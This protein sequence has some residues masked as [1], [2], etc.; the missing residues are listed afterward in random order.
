[1]TSIFHYTDVNGLLGILSS[2]ALFATHHRYLNDAT[3]AGSIRD[4]IL[5]I[6]HAEIAAIT[7]KLIEK[8]WLKK[9]YYE[10]LGSHADFLQA[11][12]MYRAFI[13]GL[14][15]TTPFFVTS[16][17][18]HPQG[19]EEYSHGLLS[20]WR[21]YAQSGGFAIEFDEAQFGALMKSENEK[22]SYA[23]LQS[24]DVHY[25]QHE[26][27]FDSQIYSGVARE[28]IY[29]MFDSQNIDVSAVTGR[30]DLDKAMVSFIKSAPLLK[31]PAFH[32]E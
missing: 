28:M 18:W 10:E 14:D 16:F 8:G 29:A 31:H 21:G 7:P 3:E 9:E 1:M 13:R 4:L 12:H 2:E 23:V 5:P 30:A 27:H 6:L 24:G 19:S 15:A 11:E 25:E 32:E 22:Y 20:Q 26:S 17:C